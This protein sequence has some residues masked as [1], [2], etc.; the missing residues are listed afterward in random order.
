MA[1][2]LLI[3]AHTVYWTDSYRIRHFFDVYIQ[4]T[5]S[6]IVLK[7]PTYT[8]TASWK[9]SSMVDAKLLLSSNSFRNVAINLHAYEVFEGEFNGCSPTLKDVR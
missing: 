3:G 2:V 8:R 4:A 1:V 6:S 5:N 9:P 7:V